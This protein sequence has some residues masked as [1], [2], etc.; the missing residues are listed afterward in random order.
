MVVRNGVQ[1]LNL[2]FEGVGVVFY[3]PPQLTTPAKTTPAKTT[4]NGNFAN[5]GSIWIK[6][7]VEIKDGE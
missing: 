5:V 2:E 3:S 7:G 4:P 1:S 6:F